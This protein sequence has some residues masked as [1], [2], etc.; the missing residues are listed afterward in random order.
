MGGSASY[1]QFKVAERHGLQRN[2]M[3]AIVAPRP[4]AWVST[5][6]KAGVGNLAPYSFFNM[7]NDRPPMVMFS[8]I[9]R[10]DTV[11]NIAETG[12]FSLST[13]SREQAEAMNLTSQDFD[14]SIDEFDCA[15]L[16]R[17]PSMLIRPPG[18][19]GCPAI[20]ECRTT[21]IRQLT[22]LDG[23]SIDTWLVIGEVLAVQLRQ[24]CIV[25]GVFRTELA[26][27]IVRAGYADEYWEIGTGG[28][29]LMER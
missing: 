13:A 26:N 19:A 10:K 1:H 15:G 21:E 23:Q 28:K 17:A 9:G 12:E 16:A 29:F 11:Q 3:K 8:S 4:I 22:L 6:S 18:V 27:P 5:L 14:G 20:L 25:D 7:V 2:P 24:D